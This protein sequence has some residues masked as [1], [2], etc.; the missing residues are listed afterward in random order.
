MSLELVAALAR[1]I[2]DN[3]DYVFRYEWS[4]RWQRGSDYTSGG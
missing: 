1:A 2:A 3:I 4:P